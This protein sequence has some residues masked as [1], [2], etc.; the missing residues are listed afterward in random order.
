M[1]R[2]QPIMSDLAI[3]AKLGIMGMT[4]IIIVLAITIALYI[5]YDQEL[6]LLIIAYMLIVTLG[7]YYLIYFLI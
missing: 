3:N 5:V 7:L 2:Y 4:G 1:S 6:V